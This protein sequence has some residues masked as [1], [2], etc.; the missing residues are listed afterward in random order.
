MA[1]PLAIR[2]QNAIAAG[3]RIFGQGVFK[4][5]GKRFFLV[6]SEHYASNN[7][8]YIVTEAGGHLD[9]NCPATKPCKH[10]CLVSQHLNAERKEAAQQVVPCE[11]DPWGDYQAARMDSAI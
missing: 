11:A 8:V 4:A 1:T 9:C 2:T 7:K 6:Q 3:M 5:T 10:I